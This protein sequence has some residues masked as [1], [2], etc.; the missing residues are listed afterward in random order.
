MSDAETEF[1][2]AGDRLERV[3]EGDRERQDRRHPAQ[4]DRLQRPEQTGLVQ[5]QGRPGAGQWPVLQRSSQGILKG[6]VPLYC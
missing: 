3:D 6:E 2:D 4:E 5:D 1:G